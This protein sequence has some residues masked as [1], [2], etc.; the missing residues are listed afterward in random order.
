M[1][2]TLASNA[3]SAKREW[4]FAERERLT[5]LGLIPDP[6]EAVLRFDLARCEQ[7]E[8]HGFLIGERYELIH[9]EIVTMPPP[10]EPH[11]CGC[12]LVVAALQL[13]FGT[14]YYV[15][16]QASLELGADEV[17]IPD[18][19]VVT[20]KP[21]DYS[22]RP[23]TALFV[24]EVSDSTYVFDITEKAELYAAAGIADYWILDLNARRLVVLRDPAPLPDGGVAYRTHLFRYANETIN[25]L[26]LP[27]AA[28]AVN[29][30]LP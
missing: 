24:V 20:G 4:S 29:D 5:D 26:A 17:P 10:N 22:T 21:R 14:G 12:A 19:A 1:S 28:V 2:T 27:S 7:L 9:G 11:N 30:L 8:A 16:G 25:P 23:N 6:S 3:A 18:A 13:A 15:R